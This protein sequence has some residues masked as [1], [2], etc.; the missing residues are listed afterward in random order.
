MEGIML[1]ELAII[2]WGYEELVIWSI[3]NAVF[4]LVELPLGYML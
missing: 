3:A 1:F 4:W 2:K